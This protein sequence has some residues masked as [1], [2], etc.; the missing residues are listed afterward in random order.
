MVYPPF[1]SFSVSG[2]QM[3]EQSDGVRLSIIGI[4]P[5]QC[6]VGPL[7][8]DERQVG[9]NAVSEIWPMDIP[10]RGRKNDVFQTEVARVYVQSAVSLGLDIF[11]F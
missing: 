11:S 6:S 10:F 4:C 9:I 5:F 8:V 2:P 3:V 7:F 1:E